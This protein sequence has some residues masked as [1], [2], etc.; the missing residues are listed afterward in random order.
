MAL[1]SFSRVTSPTGSWNP[2]MNPDAKGYGGKEGFLQPSAW[3]GG[4]NFY[5]Y[6]KGN[7]P[8]KVLHFGWSAL[9]VADFENLIDFFEDMK[10]K[11]YNF[12]FTD[13]DSQTYT[14]RF[15]SEIAW[16][17]NETGA[18]LNVSFNLLIEG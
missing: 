16:D 18:D 4:G 7:Q 2:S 6:D 17:Y 12:T 14:V 15:F 9:P 3:S 13:I 11:R 1:I 8:N 10:G 5:C